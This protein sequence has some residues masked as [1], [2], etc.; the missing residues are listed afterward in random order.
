MPNGDPQAPDVKPPDFKAI[1]KELTLG[2]DEGGWFIQVADAVTGGIRNGAVWVLG[3]LLRSVS[4]IAAF[5]VEINILAEQ[6]GDV[7]FARLASLAVSDLFGTSV[8]PETFSQR[9]GP[10]GRDAAS[11][12]VGTQIL[13]G[14]FGQYRVPNPPPLAPGD[15]G[16]AAYLGTVINLAL[17][18]WYKGV[19]VE[20]LTVGVSSQFGDLDNIIARTL[21]FGRLSRMVLGPS[22]RTL[23][24]LPVE[25]QINKAMR[26]RLL[27][28]AEAS[29]QFLRGRLTREQL[30]EELA[31][32]G[33]STE[34][35]EAV[36]NN[37]RRF[38]SLEDVGFLLRNRMWDRPTLIK[39]LRD[40]GYEA[41]FAEGIATTEE[42]KRLESIK[43]QLIGSATRARRE[44]WISNAMLRSTLT[45]LD[46]PAEEADLQAIVAATQFEMP[47]RTLGLAQMRQ[48]VLRGIRTFN[49]FRDLTDR[50]GYPD[51]D[52]VTL[53]LLLL[54]DIR[55]R[56]EA[57]QRRRRIEAERAARRLE[58]EREEAE[59]KGLT[60][61]QIQRA[62]R[63]GVASLADF[64]VWLEGSGLSANA[65]G[66]LF[67][68]L[69]ADLAEDEAR[70]A[71]QTA[72]EL[73]RG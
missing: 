55:D 71:R 49:D 73:E 1:G 15:A 66:V 46:V 13:D 19:I 24:Q 61:A 41:A 62:V 45:S 33:Y 30:D 67:E 3:F 59:G 4:E 17:E 57:D 72:A 58:R 39:A 11:A 28:G 65:Q 52:Q 54:T 34:R 43:N 16:A 35:I 25:W 6:Q 12:A 63:I 32:L 42:Q 68:T 9:T 47:R 5:L 8:T 60:L 27:S 40:Q 18:G 50:M 14:L 10:A 70:Q 36:V 51:E 64:R 38:M 31:R 7:R 48:A 22:I 26:P 37:Q 53:E 69:R 21:G 29:R 56:G 23:V 20:A 2:Q 44:G